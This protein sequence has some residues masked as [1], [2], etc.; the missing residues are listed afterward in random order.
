MLTDAECLF[1]KKD[2]PL[3]AERLIRDAIQI[4]QANHD[5]LGVARAYRL[6]GFF[7]RSPSVGGR[8]A[9]YYRKHGF[10]EPTATFVDR[11]AKSIEYFEKAE[12][13]F[14]KVG[15][16]D[17]SSGASVNKGFTYVGMRDSASACAAF[18]KSLESYRENIRLNPSATPDRPSGYQSFGAF[19]E[20]LKRKFGCPPDARSTGDS[21]LPDKSG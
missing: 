19:V 6:Y 11:Y 21:G 3:P 5:E 15:R 2:R 17:E 9:T 20:D 1:D 16:F 14:D 8:W 4:S 13:I 18:E 12:S 10:L 7:F